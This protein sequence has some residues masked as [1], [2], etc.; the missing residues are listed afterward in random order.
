M[1]PERALLRFAYVTLD[2]NN[3][4]RGTST[5]NVLL[6]T[7][8][9][10]Q[11]P[12]DM[13][14]NIGDFEVWST[15]E[16]ADLRITVIKAAEAAAAGVVAVPNA[17]GVAGHIKDIDNVK[18]SELHHLSKNWEDLTASAAAPPPPPHP[19]V[20]EVFDASLPVAIISDGSVGTRVCKC[21]VNSIDT[22]LA[23]ANIT[24]RHADTT[25]AVMDLPTGL[26]TLYVNAAAAALI[27][28]RATLS[29]TYPAAWASV[30]HGHV[31]LQWLK[32]LPL[33]KACPASC[34]DLRDLVAFA[35]VLDPA[36][37]ASISLVGPPAT[38]A[39]AAASIQ[40][41]FSILAT[42]SKI[43]NDTSLAT[44]PRVW[45]SDSPAKLGAAVKAYLAGASSRIQHP[46]VAAFQNTSTPADFTHFL[47]DSYKITCQQIV[48]AM[49]LARVSSS[50]VALSRRS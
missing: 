8:A 50:C 37:L 43:E 30:T 31:V 38:P 29:L 42:C 4:A 25:D 48:T 33:S 32:E 26:V 6:C 22:V 16:Q 36:P 20:G 3:A 23:S 18:R 11:T 21:N 9:R 34:V 40:A 17:T 27:A 28:V 14:V 35:K 1:A 12:T 45:P 10:K 15:T 47:T 5:G 13:V 46:L 7:S 39:D 24:A 41:F 44:T 2:K 19:L 49:L